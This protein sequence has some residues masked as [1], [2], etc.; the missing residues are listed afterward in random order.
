[1]LAADRAPYG[2]N[3]S[4][5]SIAGARPSWFPPASTP[6][7]PRSACAVDSQTERKHTTWSASPAETARHASATGPSC[8]AVS[9]EPRY[10]RARI[11]RLVTTSAAPAPLNP[12]SG[13]KEPGYVATP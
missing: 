7:R 12:G 6:A 5:G 10:Q 13:A 8:P 2:A 1:Q 4:Y 9:I 11:P 3:R